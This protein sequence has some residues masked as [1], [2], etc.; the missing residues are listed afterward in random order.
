MSKNNIISEIRY[1]QSVCNE[2]VLFNKDINSDI[3]DGGDIDMYIQNDSEFFMPI[4]KLR[5]WRE[6][7]SPREFGVRFFFQKKIDGKIIKL[8]LMRRLSIRYRDQKFFYKGCVNIKNSDGLR[9][10][11]PM[12]FIKYY[13][14]KTYLFEGEQKKKKKLIG[15]INKFNVSIK[16]ANV[17]YQKYCLDTIFS[18]SKITYSVIQRGKIFFNCNNEKPVY[19]LFL[20]IDG[21]GKGSYINYLS[22]NDHEIDSDYLYL[23]HNNY[24]FSLTKK[25]K[26]LNST[27]KSK[28]LRFIYH[29]C[30]IFEMYYRTM[31]VE[32]RK[33]YIF[34]DRSPT[35]EPTSTGNVIY[36]IFDWIYK[37]LS[38]TPDI[39]FYL[40]GDVHDIWRRKKE[41]SLEEMERMN[42]KLYK[43]ILSSNIP[44]IEIDT[45]TD[46]FESIKKNML[47]YFSGR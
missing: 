38:P 11:D 37:K 6:I 32:R 21:S 17:E 4:L 23:G 31:S 16:Y 39:I 2:L 28:L 22:E 19:V 5:G 36:N 1:L 24:F 40:S 30:F 25:I 13:A 33:N 44:C 15:L 43:R 46:S 20:G 26:I 3:E 18:S 47:N 42:K 8:D 29:I 34:V 9:Y 12:I 7:K 27:R 14:V 35:F 10:I 41:H 45:T